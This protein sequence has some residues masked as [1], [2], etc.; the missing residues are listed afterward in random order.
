MKKFAVILLAGLVLGGCSRVDKEPEKPAEPAA[1]DFAVIEAESFAATEELLA[2]VNA[3]LQEGSLDDAVGALS[4]ALEDEKY[5]QHRPMIFVNLL[6]MLIDAGRIDEARS[7]Y[8]EVV[9]VDEDLSRAGFSTI[10]S[11]YLNADDPAAIIEWTGVLVESPLP[12]DMAS[13]VMSWYL[14]AC[15]RQDMTDRAVEMVDVCLARFDDGSCRGI[16]GGLVQN[17]VADKKYAEAARLLTAIADKSSDRKQL[18]TMVAVSRTHLLFVQGRWIEGEKQFVQSAAVLS[19][20]EL[21]RSLRRVAP[22]AIK[23]KQGE[24]VDRMCGEILKNREDKP[25]SRREAAVQCIAVGR[26]SK[27]NAEIVRRMEMLMKFN[28]A[29]ADLLSFYKNHFHT[30]IQ[31]GKQEDYARALRY[32]DKLVPLLTDDSDIEECASMSL[33]LSFMAEDYDRS[34]KVL[35][36]GKLAQNEEWY[37]MAVNKIKAHMALRDGNHQEAV[38]RF[39]K[40]MEHVKTWEDLEYNPSTGLSHT[41]E[42]TLGFNSARIGD[43]LKSAGDEAGA[44]KA[45]AE[46]LEY[47]ETALKETVN[48]KKEQEHIK[49]ALAKLPVQGSPSE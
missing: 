14:G 33:D 18:K 4:L 17:L 37:D 40:F 7:K 29:P 13:T 46:A 41:P 45:Y 8:L 3:H 31:D 26:D 25:V 39:R 43:I 36:E 27:D 9:G 21:A 48:E 15:I 30:I 34:L 47:Y 10:Y 20:D 42:M 38:E 6:G 35:D 1:P 49:A 22:L 28:I 44:R 5:E 24:L 19:D 23:Q 11:Y 16:F 2:Q 12:D 32:G